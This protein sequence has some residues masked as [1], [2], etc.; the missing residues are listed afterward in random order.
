MT[1]LTLPVDSP[2]WLE[3]PTTGLEARFKRFHD[4]NPHIYEELEER[5]FALLRAGA[6][7]IGVKALWEAMRYDAAVRTDSR[8]WKLNNSY[9]ALY[10]RLLLHRHPELSDVIETRRRRST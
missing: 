5:A 3:R 4:A 7:R 1:Q 2:A 6:G 10:A 9:T 8:D